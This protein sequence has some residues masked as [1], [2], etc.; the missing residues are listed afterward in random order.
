MAP[1][2]VHLGKIDVVG[3]KRGE[4]EGSDEE[5]A[6]GGCGEEDGSAPAAAVSTAAGGA[7]VGEEGTCV[8]ARTA[9]AQQLHRQ[10]EMFLSGLNEAAIVDV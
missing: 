3:V 2:E 6:G 9:A 8:N 1:F 5:G 10:Q 7:A 4:D